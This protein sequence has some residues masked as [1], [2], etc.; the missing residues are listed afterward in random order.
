MSFSIHSHSLVLLNFKIYEVFKKLNIKDIF[1][2][3]SCSVLL[4][5]PKRMVSGM[6][7]S[8]LKSVSTLL[9]CLCYTKLYFINIL[10]ISL[11]R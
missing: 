8:V 6:K 4:S 5:V 3:S 10:V 9:P 2:T 11:F 1:L 7:F